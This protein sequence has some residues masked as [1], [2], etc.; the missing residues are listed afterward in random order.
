MFKD[1]MLAYY[2]HILEHWGT[3]LISET[4]LLAKTFLIFPPFFYEEDLNFKLMKFI[5]EI[6]SE[7]TK[8]HFIIMNIFLSYF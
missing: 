6:Y 4:S 3:N 7:V 8:Y 5:N 1:R 2:R